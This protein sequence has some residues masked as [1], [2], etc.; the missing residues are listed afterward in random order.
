[1][2]DDDEYIRRVK[3]KIAMRLRVSKQ[4]LNLSQ[5]EYTAKQVQV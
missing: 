2:M 4:K 3:M 1:M 5:S